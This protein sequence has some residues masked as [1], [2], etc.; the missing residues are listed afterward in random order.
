MSSALGPGSTLGGKYRLIERL[1][2]GGMGSVWLAKHEVLDAEVAVKLMSSLLA[3]TPSAKARFEREAKA[4]AQLKSLHICK[5]QDYGIEGDTPYMVMERLEGEDL[6]E[7]LN[8]RG[9]IPAEELAGIVSQIAR[10][11]TVAH[12][13]GLVH[14]DLK[15]SNVFV[16]REGD[17]EIV[18]LLDFGIARELGSQLVD[19]RTSSGMVIGSPHHMSPE[20][21]HGQ[22]V[23]HRSDL[24]S[25]GVIMYKALTG[26]RPFE[27][28]HMTAVMLRIVSTTPPAPSTLCDDLPAGTDAFFERALARDASE[29][30]QSASELAEAFAELSMGSAPAAWLTPAEPRAALPSR[31]SSLSGA[32]QGAT[33]MS[34]VSPSSEGTGSRELRAVTRG[35]D[36]SIALPKTPLVRRALPW[37]VAV[38]AVVALGLALATRGGGALAPKPAAPSATSVSATAGPAPDDAR[39]HQPSSASASV[40]GSDASPP[41][42]TPG[43]T[44]PS[45]AAAASPSSRPAIGPRP[46][47]QSPKPPAAN[48][49]AGK[50]DPFTGLP[51]P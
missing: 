43:A 21:A 47:T 38:A 33:P 5:V 8:R 35:T 40:A 36:G 4:S 48:A 15:P 42:V 45:S 9:R 30:F 1:A 22:P 6:A 27:G 12:A 18:K 39:L 16:V 10:A 24:W 51:I 25:L 34:G 37:A 17:S 31:S 7:R 19:D 28:E 11:L 44:A 13:A 41:L 50:V 2:G 3:D 23:D 20:Q 32:A 46:P 26:H 49:G 14:R 29:R